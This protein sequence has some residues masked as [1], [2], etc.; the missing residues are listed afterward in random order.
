V[1]DLSE[2]TEVDPN[3]IPVRNA[4]HLLLYAWDLAQ[5]KDKFQGDSESAPNLV[6]LLAQILVRCCQD[7]FRQ[8]LGRE[9]RSTTRDIAGL[10]GKIDISSTFK[11]DGFRQGR[12]VCRFNELNIDTPR[13]RIIKATLERLVRDNTLGLGTPNKQNAQDLRHNLRSAYQT[14]MGVSSI[15]L[16]PSDFSRL[17][18][19]RNDMRYQ[20]PLAICRMLYFTRMPT[21]TAGD[22]LITALLRDQIAFPALFEAFVRNYLRM[23]MREWHVRIEQMNWPAEVYSPWIPGMK[24]DVSMDIGDPLPRRIVLDTKYY[25]KHVDGQFEGS[26]KF[27]SAN[28][29][30]MYAYLRTQEHRSPAHFSAAGVL[31]YPTST[32]SINEAFR[33]QGHSIRVA[34]LDLSKA[35]SDI[36]DDLTAIVRVS[37]AEALGLNVPRAV[38]PLTA[39]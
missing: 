22:R 34:T 8:Q 3:Q 2:L 11:R 9:F 25:R 16:Q 31:L 35:W 17:Q 39:N 30:Q 23:T 28:L 26:Q 20:L 33:V 5:W 12:L 15:R 24:T 4:W 10:R 37:A 14:M 7:L 1:S 13:N 29:Y 6:S 36:E 19:G 32:G 38:P 27:H 18:L 21:E